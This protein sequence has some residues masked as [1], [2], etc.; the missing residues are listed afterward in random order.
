MLEILERV[1][2]ANS[3][4]KFQRKFGFGKLKHFAAALT[5]NH[6]DHIFLTPDPQTLSAWDKKLAETSQAL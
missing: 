4:I 5:H 3:V 1:G 2:L 6:T